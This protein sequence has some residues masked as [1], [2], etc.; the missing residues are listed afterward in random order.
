MYEM[1]IWKSKVKEK[2]SKKCKGLRI[3]TL[4]L[5]AAYLGIDFKVKGVVHT[6]NK[7]VCWSGRG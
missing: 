5:I 1:L 3:K 4:N 2:A 7:S 6:F